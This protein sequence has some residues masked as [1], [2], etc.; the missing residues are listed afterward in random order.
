MADVNDEISKLESE[1]KVT[2][3][4]R[5]VSKGFDDEGMYDGRIVLHLMTKVCMMLESSFI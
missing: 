3:V 5:S 2:F 1:Q 4:T